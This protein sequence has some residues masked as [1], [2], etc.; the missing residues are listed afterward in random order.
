MEK[1]GGGKCIFV[2]F[3]EI[4]NM[5]REYVVVVRVMGMKLK[6]RKYIKLS[7]NETEKL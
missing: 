2:E 6:Y 3:R 4:I 5:D 1:S 7:K